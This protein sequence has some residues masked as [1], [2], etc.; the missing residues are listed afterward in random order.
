MPVHS[1]RS[2][3]TRRS[4]SSSSSARLDKSKSKDGSE[5][6]LRSFLK[7]TIKMQR[8]IRNRF[9]WSTVTPEAMKVA[10]SL[11]PHSSKRVSFGQIEVRL[12]PVIIGDSPTC[13]IGPPLTLHWEHNKSDEFLTSVDD[14]E[15]NHR[16]SSILLNLK[17]G[18]NTPSLD[19]Y[20]RLSVNDREKILKASGFSSIEIRKE[21]EAVNIERMY[22]VRASRVSDAD[23]KWSIINVD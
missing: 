17:E 6:P 12:F 4:S 22:R 1:Q 13:K 20:E 11:P 8:K 2:N 5:H 10:S 3:N 16:S 9:S 18:K 14:F 19:Y 7:K 15:E 21:L 23:D